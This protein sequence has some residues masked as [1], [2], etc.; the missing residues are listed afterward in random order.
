MVVT[1]YWSNSWE[2]DKEDPTLYEEGVPEN[3][4]G[5]NNEPQRGGDARI[6]LPFE[7]RKRT[8]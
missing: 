1:H 8:N 6:H 2:L 3:H 5:R 7:T 4:G